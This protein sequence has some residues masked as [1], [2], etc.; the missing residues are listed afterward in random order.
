PTPDRLEANLPALHS[1][2]DLQGPAPAGPQITPAQLPHQ[3]LARTLPQ[4]PLRPHCSQSLCRLSL[5]RQPVEVPLPNPGVATAYVR[6]TGRV[7]LLH[8]HLPLR[9][10]RGGQETDPG[11]TVPRT[12]LR[13]FDCQPHQP[14]PPNVSCPGTRRVRSG[15]APDGA[16]SQGKRRLPDQ[17]LSPA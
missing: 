4:R 2:P 8:L 7:R 1:P 10:T 13:R 3:D 6:R 15:G 12:A 9:S 11:R 14:A 5:Y 16:L 17:S